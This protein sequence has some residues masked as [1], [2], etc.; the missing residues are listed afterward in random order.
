VERLREATGDDGFDPARRPA[1]E[2]QARLL[3]LLADPAYLGCGHLRLLIQHPDQYRVRP[4]LTQWFISTSIV[5]TFINVIVV[6][7]VTNVS[8]V[9]RVVSYRVVSCRVV[10]CCVS[11]RVVSCRGVL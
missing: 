2:D 1:R 10:S 5:T 9:V 7:V 4:Q 6:V 3:G 11:C 8:C